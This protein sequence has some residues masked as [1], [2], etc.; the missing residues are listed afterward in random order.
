MY[1]G[2]SRIP[3]TVNHIEAGLRYFDLED[4]I[5]NQKDDKL[6]NFMISLWVLENGNIDIGLVAINLKKAMSISTERVLELIPTLRGFRI[7]FMLEEV[8]EL[9]SVPAGL[10]DGIQVL[11]DFREFFHTDRPLTDAEDLMELMLHIDKYMEGGKLNI[12]LT[13]GGT[14]EHSIASQEIYYNIKDNYDITQFNNINILNAEYLSRLGSIDA[15]DVVNIALDKKIEIIVIDPANIS[16]GIPDRNAKQL[17]ELAAREGIIVDY[18]QQ[19]SSNMTVSKMMYK[20]MYNFSTEETYKDGL[21]E[22]METLGNKFYFT[23]NFS[24]FFSISLDINADEEFIMVERECKKGIGYPLT[25][26]KEI[27]GEYRVIGHEEYIENTRILDF[28][29]FTVPDTYQIAIIP[30]FYVS[31]DDLTIPIE[32]EY[33]KS[34]VQ[35][36]NITKE[37]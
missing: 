31:S 2:S 9:N 34:E 35:L 26:Y 16:G 3:G 28:E 18:T 11:S 19:T 1:V 20:E 8:L 27:M 12:S 24:T 23:P 30:D 4:Y 14:A 22:Y 5:E 33:K 29:P 21:R 37:R 25:E 6:D 10:L 7:K 17:I 36:G 32:E 13:S 15:I